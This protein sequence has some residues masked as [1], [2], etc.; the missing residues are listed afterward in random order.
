MWT[1]LLFITG[2]LALWRCSVAGWDLWQYERLGPEVPASVTSWEMLPKGSQYALRATYSYEYGG[3]SWTGKTQL[4]KPYYLN[5][6][7]AEGEIQKMSGM[8]WVVWVDADHPKC[9]SLE[10]HFP[11]RELFYAVCL[12]GIFLYFVYL[13]IHLEL[14]SRA[15]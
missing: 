10:K 11:L 12:L 7:S 8:P 13:K 14:L 1:I 3:K 2:C 4:R 15:W 9:S 5:R 6:A